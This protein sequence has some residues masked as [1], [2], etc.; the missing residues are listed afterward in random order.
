MKK[1]TAVALFL[2]VL[3]SMNAQYKVEPQEGYT[4]QIGSMVYMLEDLKHRITDMVK[5]LDTYQTDYQIDKDANSIGSLILHL[6][7]TEAYFQ[8]ETLENRTFTDEEEQLWMPG[9]GL[10]DEAKGSSK[11]KPIDYYLNLW[12]KVR[13][14]TLEGLKQKDDQWFAKSIDESMN[15]HWA[16]YHVMEHQANHMGQIAHIQNRIPEKN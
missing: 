1:I 8:V 16:W 10:S 12:N 6:A 15:Y 13:L 2:F 11:G 5:N 14:K 3:G 7:S 4:T 9:A